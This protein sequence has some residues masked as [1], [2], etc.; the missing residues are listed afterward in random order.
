[1]CQKSANACSVEVVP[2][3]QFTRG[4]KRGYY[5][6]CGVIHIF[7]PDVAE[8]KLNF[9]HRTAHGDAGDDADASAG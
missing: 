9:T 4:G 8:A 7:E 2:L 6:S 3:S 1:M 5:E